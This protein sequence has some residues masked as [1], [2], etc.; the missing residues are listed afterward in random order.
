MAEQTNSYEN[1]FSKVFKDPLYDYIKIDN[2]ICEK[3]ID[4]R[5]F[6]RLRRIE[7][8]SMRCLYPSARHDRFIH[9]IGV[10]H[11][12]K[13][14]I[15]ALKNNEKVDLTKENLDFPD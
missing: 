13:I 9:S 4:N 6:Q 11:L 15:N 14:A 1:I 8:T 7:Q 5:Y 10:Y 12:A 3:I 2:D